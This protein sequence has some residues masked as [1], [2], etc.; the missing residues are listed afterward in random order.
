M[1]VVARAA[2]ELSVRDRH[3]GEARQLC[4]LLLVTLAA[5]LH[6]GSLREVPTLGPGMHQAMAIRARDV[7]RFV[8]TSLPERAS[9][10]LVT[11]EARRVAHGNGRRRLL[12]KGN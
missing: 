7:A 6:H 9:G 8:R 2:L 11:P 5:R 10:F 3:V 1:R 4:D 12:P